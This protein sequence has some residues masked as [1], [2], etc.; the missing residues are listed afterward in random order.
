MD[1]W[2]VDVHDLIG[3]PVVVAV[4]PRDVTSRT[5]GGGLIGQDVPGTRQGGGIGC[6]LLVAALDEHHPD[7]EGKGGDQ[8]QRDETACEQDEDLPSLVGTASC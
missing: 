8:E 5:D 6:V 4:H 2:D 1:R 3:G 7:V